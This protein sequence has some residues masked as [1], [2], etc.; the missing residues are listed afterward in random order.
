M[1]KP[2]VVT[3]EDIEA[4]IRE[5]ARLDFENRDGVNPYPPGSDA[6]KIWFDTCCALIRLQKQKEG[7][8]VSLPL[9][10]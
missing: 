10:T 9:S 7:Q 4:Q 6:H 3:A 1:P 8:V 5:H 2:V